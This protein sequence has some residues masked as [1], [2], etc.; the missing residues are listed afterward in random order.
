MAVGHLGTAMC[1]RGAEQKRRYLAINT[2]HLE[3]V[4]EF[5]ARDQVLEN[6]DTFKYL[7]RILSYNYSDCAVVFRSLHR[8]RSKWGM[9]SG[10]MF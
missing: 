3:V 9:F 5:R 2:I 1:K 4:M 6:V 10:M 7:G 8:E